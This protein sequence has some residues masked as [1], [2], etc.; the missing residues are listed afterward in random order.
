[1]P[2]PFNTAPIHPSWRPTFTAA[3]QKL[4]ADYIT[5]LE[6]NPAG[7]LPGPMN[8]FNAFCLPIDRVKYI[9]MG[10]SPY[11]RPA[12]A[13]GFAFWD[14]A[15]SQ[16]WSETGLSKPVNRATSLRNFIKMLLVA[17]NQLKENECSQEAI[18]RLPKKNLVLTIE[19]LFNNLMSNGFLLL[20][21]SLVLSQTLVK[22][23]AKMWLPFLDSIL[24]GLGNKGITLLLFGKI[25]KN[26]EDLP[27]AAS[28]K[29]L[30]AEHP[31]NISF[32]NNPDVL[33][34]FRPFHLLA[35]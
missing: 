11:P 22:K 21:A 27:V 35:A 28:F 14:A 23:E 6:E 7:W 1:M 4:P 24:K 8:I 20:N 12:S 17:A 30:H 33:N 26:I 5:L 13:N 25:A 29:Q 15:V 2:L 10:E 16:L 19:Q 34:F 18:A 3:L 31:Y 9:L 32:I